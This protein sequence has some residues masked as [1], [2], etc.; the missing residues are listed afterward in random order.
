MG[1]STVLPLP[2]LL[3]S[4][5]FE[6]LRV[7]DDRLNDVALELI[8]CTGAAFHR[9]LI[10][11]A[12]DTKN[13]PKHRARLLKAVAG[14]RAVLEGETFFDVFSLLNDRHEEVCMAAAD[15]I[16]DHPELLAAAR[17]RRSDNAQ[18]G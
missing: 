15:V 18:G 16:N 1:P 7:T 4:L 13:R 3:K 14:T 10:D 8:R 9:D 5:L 2:L 12:L 6:S 11:G 17:V